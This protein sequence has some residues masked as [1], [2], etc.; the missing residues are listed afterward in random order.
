MQKVYIIEDEVLLRDLI[1]D[2]LKSH[3]N[4]EII[5]SSGDGQKGMNEC[6]KLKP[7][8]VILDVRLPSLNG[9]EIA[10]RLKSEFPYIK[11]LMFSG[12]FNLGIIK[13]LLMA[14]VNGIIEKSAG[15]KEMEKA[16]GIVL[17]GQSYFGPTIVAKMPELLSS[18]EN[19]QSVES[20]TTRER[21]VLQ[22]IAEGYTNKEISERLFISVRTAD[23]HRTHIMQKLDVHNVAGLTRLAI[24]HGLV[25][26][27]ETLQ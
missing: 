20:L 17:G 19:E 18:A 15:L 4:L 27:P 2:L 6:L 26:L 22:L 3:A 7:Q 21:E 23:V 14:K 24:S 25:H 13:R 10:Q 8:M 12:L 11:I 16:I 1:I 5:G 9:V